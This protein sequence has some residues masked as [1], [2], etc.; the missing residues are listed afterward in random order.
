MTLITLGLSIF[1]PDRPAV[2]ADA[3]AARFCSGCQVACS[4]GES[5]AVQL[6]RRWQLAAEWYFD[7]GLADWQ[8]KNY[9]NAL[10]IE[11]AD[12]PGLGRALVVRRDDRETDTAFEIASP[13]VAVVEG[14]LCRL[15]IA[16]AH[17]LD[18][19]M[20]QGHGESFWNQVRWVDGEGARVGATPF[21]FTGAGD[22]WSEVTVETRAPR[23]AAAAVIQIGFDTPNLY[24]ERQ[25]RLREVAWAAQPDPPQ[26]VAEGELIARPQCLAEPCRAGRISWQADTPEGTSVRFQVRSAADADGGPGDWTPFA[27]PDGSP[28]SYFMTS[29]AA[30][31]ALHAGHQWLQYRLV[32]ATTRPAVTPEVREVRLGDERCWVEDCGWLGPDREPPRLADYAPRR[33][34]DPRQP[35]VFSLS[36]GADG[37]GVD[38]HSVEVLLDGKPIAVEWQRAENAFRYELR[39]PRQGSEDGPNV[40]RVLVK[41]GDFAGNACEQPGGILVQPP[42][43]SG[44]ATVRDDGGVVVDGRPLFPIGLYSVWKREHNGHDFDRCFTELR[45]A[46]FNT[47]HT[48]QTRRDAELEEFYAAADRHRL[49]VIIAPRGGANRRDAEAAVRTVAEE[50]RQPALLAWYLADDTA[51]HISA[52]EL[53]RVHRALDDVDPFH[54]TVQADAVFAGPGRSRYA[55]YVDATDAFLPELYPIRSDKDCE[56]ADVT[57]DMKLIEEDL[58]RAGRRAPVWAI[59]QD[60]EGWGWKRYPTLA[61]TRVMTYL[62]VIHGAKGV[63][64]YTYGGTG[65]NHGVTHDPEVWAGLKRIAGELAT[66]HDVLVQRDPPQDQR[67]EILSGPQED[68]LGYPAVSWL[69]KQH[70]GRR[71]LLVANSSRSAVRARI[72]AGREAGPVEVLFEDRRLAAESNV[73]EDDFAPYAVHVYCW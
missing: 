3:A 41:A 32:L 66:L 39:E 19:G 38:R 25:F 31:P 49:R 64:Y 73:W 12:H 72:T 17:T 47:I 60:F 30:L 27:G 59:I 44:I 36:D 5:H 46:G 70:Q 69:L 20:A 14:S 2:A 68:G 55:D 37:T 9:Q 50:C 48:Y 8:V 24:G 52:A 56:V 57:R 51:S 34:D 16:A 54:I 63:T 21:R 61:E 23:G 45:E 7:R 26:F 67:I 35:L 53:G 42:A 65:G 71:Y 13:P 22:A 6:A 15:T 58:C 10:K 29:G 43:A 33:T 62:A 40:H 4:P 1:K 11:N 18:L 28:D